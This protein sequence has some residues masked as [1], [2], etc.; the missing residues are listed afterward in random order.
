MWMTAAL[1]P[2]M[3]R[4]IADAGGDALGRPDNRARVW[5]TAASYPTMARVI[6]DAGGDA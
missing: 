4:V 1:Y 5:M 3:A 2:T 6:A